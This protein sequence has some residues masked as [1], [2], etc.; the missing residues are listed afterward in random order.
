LDDPSTG[1]VIVVVD[2]CRDGTMELLSEWS[3]R[4]PRLRVLFQE[5][6]GE[7]AA[8]RYGIREARYDVVVL[9]D[10]D[11]SACAGLISGHA[12]W[13]GADTHRL[14]VGYMPTFVPALR[15][16]GNATTQLYAEYYEATTQLYERDPTSIFANLWAGNMSI[17]RDDALKVVPD[18]QNRL[19][20]HEDLRFGLQCQAGGLE[21][22]FDRSLLASHSYSRT[23]RGFAAESSR[24]GEARARLIREHPELKNELDPTRTFS[25]REIFLVRYRE[26]N[27]F[28]RSTTVPAL[29]VLTYICGRLRMWNVER[30]TAQ[31]LG[32]LEQSVSFKDATLS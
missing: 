8:R 5:N 25:S 32:A 16:P 4:E 12:R 27:F 14:V 19:G 6:G 22:V 13:H 10:D 17:K 30:R 1:E 29:M 20:Y 15:R 7:T 9:L 28:T 26:A 24:S 23:L 2:G 3:L 21:P 18:M 11:V 31:L